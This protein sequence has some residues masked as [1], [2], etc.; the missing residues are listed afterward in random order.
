MLTIEEGAATICKT[1]DRCL[2][3]ETGCLL[4]RNGSTELT[5]L[6]WFDV[7]KQCGTQMAENLQR[8]SGVFPPS[9]NVL[10]DWIAQYKAAL[11]TIEKEPI[12]AG[13]FQGLAEYEANLLRQT[14]PQAQ[15]MPLRCLEPYYVA[16]ELRWTRLL[17]GQ[18]VAVVS[19]FAKTIAKQIERRAA[20]WGENFESLLPSTTEW[21]PIQTGFPPATAK[22][23]LEWPAGCRS[24]VEAVDFLEKEVVACGAR[25]CL[26]GCG[27]LGMVLG[28][29]L[30]K[31]GIVCIVM[32]GAIQVLFGIRGQRWQTHS[33][34]GKFWNDAWVWPSMDEIPGDAH[35][36]EGG[37][38][39]N[40]IDGKTQG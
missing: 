27:A 31:R 36:I 16:P 7:H 18:K 17:A 28:A 30:K 3:T 13:W 24:W 39:W 19:S 4:G 38:Y 25:I 2:V 40:K 14:C 29:R 32:G 23:C 34:I 15:Q 20:I 5:T 37:C 21:F 10:R 9:V 6:F 22:G 35:S 26:I 8:Y 1:I 11:S 33:V 12:V